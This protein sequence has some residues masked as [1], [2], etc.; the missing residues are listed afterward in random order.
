[1]R[2]FA[3]YFLLELKKDIRMLPWFFGSILLLMVL[4]FSGTLAIS[5]VFLKGQVFDAITVDMA[6]SD[7][8][9]KVKLIADVLSSM[10]SVKNICRFQ[11]TTEEEARAHLKRGESDA[12]IIIRD[13]F[14][15]DMETGKNTPAVILFPVND[16]FETRM[17]RQLITDGVSLI[18]TTEA[19]VYAATD[20][21]KTY[22]LKVSRKEMEDLIFFSYIE[23]AFFR[24]EIF[25]KHVVSA[26]GEYGVISYYGISGM[27]ICLLMCGLNF[28]FMYGKQEDVI[29]EKLRVYGIGAVPSSAVK[30]LTAGLILW[31]ISLILLCFLQMAGKLLGFWDLKLGQAMIGM[32]PVSLSISSIFHVVYTY[33]RQGGGVVLFF[34][35]IGMILCSGA[36]IPVRYLP[37]ALQTA[38]TIM[39][40][41]YWEIHGAQL[42][43]GSSDGK[44]FLLEGAIIV[45]GILI[46]SLKG[47]YKWKKD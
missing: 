43:F 4:V 38:G 16:T 10:E 34:I 33:G 24:G 27:M 25:Q 8:E 31:M 7:H 39:P 19:A 20:A 6:V 1:M 41:S 22:G 13:D 17:F 3:T 9:T 44:W 14:Y 35:N 5:Q 15:K 28:S 30:L 26:T 2:Q 40:L 46:G 36:L 32:L 12:A 47:C 11:Y 18:Q 23:K 42:C 45:G 37:K 29:A 21:G